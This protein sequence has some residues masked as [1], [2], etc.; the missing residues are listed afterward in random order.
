[1]YVLNSN[2]N[3]NYN[4]S[5]KK[6]EK[7]IYVYV[8]IYINIIKKEDKEE[9][10]Y[11]YGTIIRSLDFLDVASSWLCHAH[12]GSRLPFKVIWPP[13]FLSTL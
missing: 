13:S 10:I 6:K 4:G 5:D 8:C 1:M 3:Y 11:E 9:D 7:K 2:N 12:R